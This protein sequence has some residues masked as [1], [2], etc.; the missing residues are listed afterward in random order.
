MSTSPRAL[1][2]T[3]LAAG[4]LALA[5]PQLAS[6]EE[7]T[8]SATRSVAVPPSS[9][10]KTTGAS[11]DGWAVAFS[12]TAIYQI[13]HHQS[14]LAVAC[15]LQSSGASC[16]EPRTITEAGEAFSTSGHSGAYVDEATGKLYVYATR[17]KDG[18]GGVVCIDLNE[19]E[20]NPD[21]FCGF[22]ALTQAGQAPQQIGHSLISTPMLVGTRWYAFNYV[23]GVN[24]SGAKNELLCF[25]VSSDE[26]CASQP[27]Q[28]PIGAGNVEEIWPGPSSAV[29]DSKLLIPLRI[30]GATRI[31]CY[32]AATSA[33]CAGSWPVLPANTSA[34][35]SGAPFPLLDR[36]GATQGFCL[37]TGADEC[38]TLEG[39]TTATPP[40]MSSVI[41]R[42]DEYNGPAVVLGPRVYVPNGESDEEIGDIECYDYAT[43]SG[44]ANFPKEFSHLYYLYTVQ[45][46][47]QRPSCLW[48][49]S[50][51]GEQQIQNFDAYT[52]GACG[53]GPTRGLGA[54]FVAAGEQCKPIS[55][56]SLQVI[57]PAPGEYAT[58][59]VGF[60]DGDGEQIEGVAEQPLGAGGNLDLESLHLATETGLPQFLF[61]FT[62]AAEL[63]SIEV[64]LTWRGLYSEN[65]AGEGRT[66]TRAPIPPSPKLETAPTPSTPVPAAVLACTSEQLALVEVAQ[67]GSHVRL[68]GVARGALAGRTVQ[69]T[70]A[71][72]GQIVA[73][74]SVAPDGT[75]TASAPLPPRAIRDGN[76]ARYVASIGSLHSLPLK[77]VR[78]MYMS[79]IARTTGGVQLR[80]RVTG[81]FR[82][83]TLVR[84][85]MR[86]TCGGEREVGRARLERNGGFSAVVPA[87]SPGNGQ[88]IVYRAATTVMRDHT[89]FATYTVPRAP[90][91]G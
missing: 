62:G 48:V 2:L 34:A 3:L 15:H 78:R 26:P 11:G 14:Y 46:D 49:N 33:P 47:P 29:I 76:A 24:I 5:A 85:L 71:A 63:G 54:Q 73:T 31:A 67:R 59:T 39:S 40:G 64:K 70:L 30:G 6:A 80:G 21:P 60:A 4:L 91:Q 74:S 42:S 20:T 61:H 25:D 9:N 68:E 18:T 32:D 19:A 65:C 51:D 90:T 38:F 13:F 88:V 35:F 53:S 66:V 75:F 16:W 17:N 89:P 1:S 55:Y 28:L 41:E 81:A 69:I 72:T 56:I 52:G 36:S 57:H 45:Q 22:T 50:D 10:F 58:G 27:Y 86:E 77:L 84:I 83:G 12:K 82:P 43:D 79:S 7:A 8:Y 37:P 87:T 44:C 23:E